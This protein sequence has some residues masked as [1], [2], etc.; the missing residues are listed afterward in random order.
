MITHTNHNADSDDVNL[1]LTQSDL[2]I[3]FDV[4]RSE[5]LNK[6]VQLRNEYFSKMIN[7]LD[8]VDKVQRG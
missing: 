6:L 8:N 7:I 5:Y 1:G 4:L 3:E 2:I